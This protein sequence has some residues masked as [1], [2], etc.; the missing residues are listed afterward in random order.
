MLHGSVV[1][2]GTILPDHLNQATCLDLAIPGDDGGILTQD[3][4][5]HE[6]SGDDDRIV[7]VKARG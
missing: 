6:G 2:R 5:E 1:E 7:D 3:I 4:T